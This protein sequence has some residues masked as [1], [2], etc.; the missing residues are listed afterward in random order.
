MMSAWWPSTAGGIARTD[1]TPYRRTMEIIRPQGSVDA[2]D[3]IAADEPYRE[4]YDSH[5]P[6]VEEDG[7]Q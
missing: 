7:G 6:R 1:V 2:M 4:R 3:K 5:I